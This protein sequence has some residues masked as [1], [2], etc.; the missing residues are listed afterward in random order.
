MEKKKM[1]LMYHGTELKLTDDV[2]DI[3]A[4]IEMLSKLEEMI[5]K[6]IKMYPDRHLPCTESHYVLNQ[7]CIIKLATRYEEMFNENPTIRIYEMDFYL[8]GKK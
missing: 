1:K 6:H 4:R 3:P 5:N 2:Y 8:K 7:N